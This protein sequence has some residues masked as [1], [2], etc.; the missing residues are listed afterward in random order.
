M[1]RLYLFCAVAISVKMVDGKKWNVVETLAD[2]D[3]YE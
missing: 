2:L 1:H 3:M